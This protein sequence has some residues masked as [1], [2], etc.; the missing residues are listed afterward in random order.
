MP[1][2]TYRQKVKKEQHFVTIPRKEYEELLSF[3][4]AMIPVFKPTKSEI[5]ALARARKE[6]ESGDYVSWQELK[7]ELANLRSRPR[8]KTV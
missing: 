2:L 3:K 8:K 6:F 5:Q 7:Y 4:K 1:T